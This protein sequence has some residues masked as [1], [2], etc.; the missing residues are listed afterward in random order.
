[1]TPSVSG[2]AGY[3]V[4]SSSVDSVTGTWSSGVA[5]VVVL[6]TARRSISVLSL[7]SIS[8]GRMEDV[9][10]TLGSVPSIAAYGVRLMP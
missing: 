1:M 10:H 5:S 7:S 3:K 2:V 8:D 4:G 9:S 6:R